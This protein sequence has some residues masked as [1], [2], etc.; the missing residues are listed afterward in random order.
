MKTAERRALA[1]QLRL[2]AQKWKHP[3]TKQL[4]GGLEAA[5][6]TVAAA[7]SAGHR[8]FGTE[9]FLDVVLK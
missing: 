6:R 5:L 7:V 9:A 2:I 8:T 4:P 3:D 1:E